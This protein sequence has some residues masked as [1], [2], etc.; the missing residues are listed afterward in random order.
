MKAGYSF[1]TLA[2]TYQAIR[3][4]NMKKTIKFRFLYSLNNASVQMELNH[5]FVPQVFSLALVLHH[6]VIQTVAV[7]IYYNPNFETRHTNDMY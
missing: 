5:K 6:T 1:E 3:R 4:Q 2:T 7:E